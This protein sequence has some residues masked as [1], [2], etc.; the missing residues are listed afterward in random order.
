VGWTRVGFFAVEVGT[1]FAIKILK[2]PAEA[3]D[4]PAYY[5]FT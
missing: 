1:T 4:N 3:L 5:Y 2:N